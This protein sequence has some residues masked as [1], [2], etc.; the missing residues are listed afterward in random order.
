MK[1]NNCKIN[2]EKHKGKKMKEQPSIIEPFL[3]LKKSILEPFEELF[4]YFLFVIYLSA[5]ISIYG[6]LTTP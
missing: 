3:E 6:P 2:Q 1:K 5:H 4:Y